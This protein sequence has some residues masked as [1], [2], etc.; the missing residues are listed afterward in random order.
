M[1]IFDILSVPNNRIHS[2]TPYSHIKLILLHH[3]RISAQKY[4]EFQTVFSHTPFI[5]HTLNLRGKHDKME[6]HRKPSIY[7]YRIHISILSSDS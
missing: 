7:M 4:L 1:Q 6:M 2:S 5:L 3:H